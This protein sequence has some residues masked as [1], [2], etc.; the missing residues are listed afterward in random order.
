MKQKYVKPSIIV[1]RFA[2]TQSIA[3]GCGVVGGSTLGSPMQQ[4]KHDCA[5]DLGNQLIFLQG[6]NVCMDVQVEENDE[7]FGICYNNP[8]G[9]M[10]FGSL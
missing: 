3:S 1:E 4:N 5:W 9:N 7:V 10:I 6:M 2:L 8:N